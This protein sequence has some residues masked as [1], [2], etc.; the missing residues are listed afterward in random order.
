M[1]LFNLDKLEEAAQKA[2]L[3]TPAKE[4]DA[5]YF[6]LLK[7]WRDDDIIPR[8]FD[9]Y[10]LNRPL[11]G[12]SSFIIN[13]EAFFNRRNKAE[14][15]YKSQAIKLMARRDLNLYRQFNMDYLDI[16]FFPDLN[17]QAIKYNP[18]IEIKGSHIYFKTEG[19]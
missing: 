14:S 13:P 11:T 15:V 12:G 10:K 4:D 18:L 6:L 7:W 9:K 5:L 3:A 19:N 17:I 16:S 8:R 1:L 2:T